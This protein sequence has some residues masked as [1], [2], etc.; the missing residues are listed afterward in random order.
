MEIGGS[1]FSSSEIRTL[2]PK[3]STLH[4]RVEGL[5]F[6]ATTPSP[7][8]AKGNT[9]VLLRGWSRLLLHGQGKLQRPPSKRSGERL[10]GTL[11]MGSIVVPFWDYLIGS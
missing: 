8:K 10:L 1:D 2:Y 3:A 5:R 4:P 9:A 6:R 7:P 11:L